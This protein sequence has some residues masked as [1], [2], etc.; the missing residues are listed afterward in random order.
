MS[1]ISLNKEYD[2][3]ADGLSAGRLDLAT[4]EIAIA[5]QD[6]SLN[7]KR[8]E[9]L[10]VIGKVGSGK[11]SLLLSLLGEID[12]VRGRVELNGSCAF[13][14]QEP[15]IFPTSV[16]NNI[17]YGRGWD[18]K[19]YEKVIVACCLDVDMAQLEKGDLT[20][21][22]ER[23]ITLSGGQRARISLAMAVYA[24]FDIY[25]LDDPLSS[26]DTKV[27]KKI[28]SIFTTGLLH[29]KTVILV[30]HQLQFSIHADK[31][32]QLE[33][34]IE[35]LTPIERNEM[36]FL[37]NSQSDQGDRLNSINT[38]SQ[39]DRGNYIDSIKMNTS[40]SKLVSPMDYG[41]ENQAFDT[42]DGT[43]STEKASILENTQ[44]KRWN[45]KISLLEK[46][47]IN[48]KQTT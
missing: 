6:I 8:G 5:I 26:V 29:T 1:R 4:N 48:Y 3:I 25:L 41:Y 9:F 27:G 34:G 13:V 19:W 42:D 39:S 32:L 43:I 2:I 40:V 12:I 7:L 31:V 47:L 33:D 37:D 18:E 23:G 10:L 16:R 30:T 15:W 14:P 38:A 45:S 21:V 36:Q 35:V 28:L 24:N 22:G 20:I 11:S 44:K 17:I 46:G